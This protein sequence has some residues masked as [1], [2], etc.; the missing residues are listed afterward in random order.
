MANLSNYAS[1]F[2]KCYAGCDI[3]EKNGLIFFIFGTVINH[4]GELMYVKKYI[5]RMLLFLF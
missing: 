3:S 2:L 5:I 4:N 1:I